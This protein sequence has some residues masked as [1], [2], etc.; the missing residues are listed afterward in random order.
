MINDQQRHD[1]QEMTYT[2]A[3]LYLFIPVADP[4]EL[5]QKFLQELSPLQLCGTLLIAP[6]G[7]NGTLAGSEL[8]IQELL[9]CLNNNTGLSQKDVKFSYSEE[10][11]FNRFK[12]RLKREIVTFNQP[13]VNPNLRV[14]TYIEPD[15]W[16]TLIED[17]DVTVIDTRNKYE[18]L[19]GTFKNAIDPKI[20]SFTE[21]SDY[22]R[23]NLDPK[24]H[25]KIAMFCTGG[26]R[27]EKAS[28][29]MLAEGFESVFHLKGGILKYLEEIPKEQ[30]R[31]QG[32]CYVF[33]RRMAVGHG[34]TTGHYSMCYC[35]GYPLSDKDKTHNLYEEGV[36]CAHC[37]EKTSFEN[38]SNYRMRHKQLTI[39]Q[40]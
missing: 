4:A 16:N 11:P 1:D 30:S 26:I 14:G 20:D 13:H 35:C 27:C 10:K 12:I 22:V 17:P 28:S 7:I 8:A 6:E 23:E 15:Q 3:A 39:A 5:K 9:I 37:Y 19:I 24:K 18:T 40:K 36:S 38:K 25:K 21:F 32:D 31:W 33:D 34:L 2:I 29:F